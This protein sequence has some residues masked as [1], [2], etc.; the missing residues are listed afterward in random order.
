[1]ARLSLPHR[2][3]NAYRNGRYDYRGRRVAT[4]PGRRS[5]H[6]AEV[7]TTG[8]GE[9]ASGLWFGA[10]ADAVETLKRRNP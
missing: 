1:M 9:S 2:N 5:D 8:P 4:N 3:A 10:A 7:R 6:P